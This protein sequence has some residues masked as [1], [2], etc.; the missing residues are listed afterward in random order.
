LER[1]TIKHGDS[2]GLAGG[3]KRKVK[4]VSMTLCPNKETEG[5]FLDKKGPS[6]IVRKKIP[7]GG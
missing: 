3:R 5:D 7:C 2:A 6:G 1:E 4:D